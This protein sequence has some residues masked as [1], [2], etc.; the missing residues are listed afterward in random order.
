MEAAGLMNTFP[1]LVIRGIC[2]Y[3]DS[4]KDKRWQPHAA[5]IAAA[6]AK[7]LLSLVHA[8]ETGPTL[9]EIYDTNQA[10]AV[11]HVLDVNCKN[12]RVSLDF[13]QMHHRRLVIRK[14]YQGTGRCLS[15]IPQFQAWLRGDCQ[16]L[17]IKGKAGS[18]KSTLMKRTLEE[19]QNEHADNSVTI[20]SFFYDASGHMLEHSTIGVLRSVLHQIFSQ[21]HELLVEFMNASDGRFV[22]GKGMNWKVEELMAMFEISCGLQCWRPTILLLDGLDE[23]LDDEIRPLLH[24]LQQQIGLSDLGISTKKL[25]VL[26]SSR[27]YPHISVD[28]CPEIW[29]E[30]HNGR[31][32][33]TFTLKKIL[34]SDDHGESLQQTMSAFE[35]TPQEL[36]GLYMQILH[37]LTDD[38]RLDTFRL[39]SWMLFADRRLSPLELCF[40]MRFHR[41]ASKVTLDSW[42]RSNESVG[43]NLQAEKFVR[44]RSRGL[45][46]IQDKDDSQDSGTVQFIHHTVSV[47]LLQR[48]LAILRPNEQPAKLIGVAHRDIALTC[49]LYL[50]QN[51][52]TN[53]ESFSNLRSHTSH[54]DSCLKGKPQIHPVDKTV[55]PLAKDTRLHGP[56]ST[57]RKPQNR[58][59]E[60]TQPSFGK[61]IAS[62]KIRRSMSFY[63]KE[64][65]LSESG[66]SFKMLCISQEI[67]DGTGLTGT[68]FSRA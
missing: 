60:P 26:F 53:C 17:W 6:Y 25:Q 55:I 9:R 68:V 38:E 42:K 32:I 24:F 54:F 16:F 39:F 3:A 10:K 49:V 61:N 63:V 44:S 21:N 65:N 47:F 11:K 35:A 50:T 30:N 5:I 66:T 46:N 48:G 59:Y 23:G 34:K 67:I 29:V 27:H 13:T 40:A 28:N 12:V 51:E 22:K 7:E 31:D 1:C 41:N 64:R 19:L 2:D 45:L 43:Q 58:E 37:K 33:E 36:D 57:R 52:I 15:Q 20:A 4:H 14:P 62:P 56:V 18:G 8:P